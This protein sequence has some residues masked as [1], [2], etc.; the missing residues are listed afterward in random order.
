MIVDDLTVKEPKNL[1]RWLLLLWGGIGIYA[2]TW[3]HEDGK[4]NF[5]RWWKELSQEKEDIDYS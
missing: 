4:N 5:N 3:G 2:C 1:L